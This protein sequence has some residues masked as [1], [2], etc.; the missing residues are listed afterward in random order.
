MST[1]REFDP[2]RRTTL[3][4]GGAMMAGLVAAAMPGA[5][6][7]QTGPGAPGVPPNTTGLPVQDLQRILRAPG[8]IMG[9][10]LHITQLRR[11]LNDVVGPADIPFKPAFAVHNDFYFQ[12]LPNGRAV[13]NGELA[14]R[15]EEIN[16]VIDRI[17]STGLIL[18]SFHQHF[19]NLDPQIWH[20]HLRASGSPYGVARGV[21]YVVQATGTPLPQTAPQNP[22]STLDVPR[23]RRILGG[24]TEIHEDGVV[25]VH[26]RRREDVTLGGVPIDARL[27]IGHAVHFEPLADG[28]TAVAPKFALLAQEIDT[29]LR[30]MRREGFDVHCLY[31]QETAET[32]QLYFSHLLAVGNPYWYAR[33]IRRVLQQ[34]NTRFLF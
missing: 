3:A 4:A 25:A 32:P 8:R 20:V 28:R 22:T 12:S 9:R 26:I 16:A 30:L 7:G 11:F 29:V 21:E 23:L 31:N 14:L 34:T 18:Q 24:D 1:D 19:F 27:G 6:L 2:V 15:A 10:V 13:L 5:A 33:V 17:L